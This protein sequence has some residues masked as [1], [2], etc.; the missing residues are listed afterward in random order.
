MIV[1]NITGAFALGED[2]GIFFEEKSSLGGATRQE[3]ATFQS[4]KFLLATFN[5]SCI[6]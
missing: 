2:G 4:P 3:E 5:E 6:S 1:C